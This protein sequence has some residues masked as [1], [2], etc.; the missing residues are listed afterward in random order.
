MKL[1]RKGYRREQIEQVLQEFR[2]K[3][4]INEERY[5]DSV[6]RRLLKKN[7]SDGIIRQRLEREGV[8]VSPQDI[9]AMRKEIQLSSTAQIQQLIRKKASH[10]SLDNPK[11]EEKV[12]RHLISRGYSYEQC[13]KN[14]IE[15]KKGIF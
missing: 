5:R 4:Y 14:L 9:K 7:Y 8:S 10:L 13:R 2:Q 11:S 15:F 12:L 1:E 6:I 3:G